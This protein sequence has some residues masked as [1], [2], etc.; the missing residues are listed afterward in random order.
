MSKHD[1]VGCPSIIAVGEAALRTVVP[2]A[3]IVAEHRT[4]AD[5][6]PSVIIAKLIGMGDDGEGIAAVGG[7]IGTALGGVRAIHVT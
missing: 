2:V 5:T 1:G 7:D 6:H 4:M 3:L